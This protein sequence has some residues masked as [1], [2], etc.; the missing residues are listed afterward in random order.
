MDPI[1]AQTVSQIMLPVVLGLVML[2]MGLSLQIKD[3]KI[4]LQETID[5][6]R[7]EPFIN[8]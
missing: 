3:F 5:W 7:S 8:D 4:T 2:G 1:I 6:V